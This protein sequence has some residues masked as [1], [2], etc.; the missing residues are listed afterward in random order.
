M[1]LFIYQEHKGMF[2]NEHSGGGM[3]VVAENE[4]AAKVKEPRI[5]KFTP[6]AVYELYDQVAEKVYAFPDAGCC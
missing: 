3:V 6:I 2:D 1:K 5:A 4:E